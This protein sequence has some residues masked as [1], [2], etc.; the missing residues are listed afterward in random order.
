MYHGADEAERARKNFELQFSRRGVPESLEQVSEEQLVGGLGS[1]ADPTVVD[2]LVASGI[3]RTRSAAR[4][5]IEQRAVRVDDE[6][7]EAWDKPFDAR[8]PH[9]IRAGRQMRRYVPGS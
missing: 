2:V 8:R 4:R 9:V 6:L 7:I 3:A 5:L 1:G